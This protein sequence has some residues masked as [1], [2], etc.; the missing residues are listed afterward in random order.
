VARPLERRRVGADAARATAGDVIS[1]RKDIA[2]FGE[3]ATRSLLHEVAEVYLVG[4]VVALDD[5]QASDRAVVGELR[6]HDARG[7]EVRHVEVAIDL[8]RL[9]S[10][11]HDSPAVIVVEQLE[12][13]IGPGRVGG[14][15]EHL[16]T[17]EREL[18]GADGHPVCDR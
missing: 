15:H 13:A 17:R 9:G 5:V 11:G 2:V 4:I 7:V 14:D 6:D 12:A 10:D 18:G 3:H 1:H 8:G 16:A